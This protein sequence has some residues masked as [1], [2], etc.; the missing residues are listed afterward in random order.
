[1]RYA[2]GFDTVTGDAR[3]N[4][5]IVMGETGATLDGGAGDDFIH[6]G[7]GDD[8]FLFGRGSGADRVVDNA[9][10][11]PNGVDPAITDH[12]VVQF[13]ANID[14]DQLWFEQVGDD[15]RVSV[16][17]TADSI[18]VVDWYSSGVYL[19]GENRIDEFK[20]HSG[21]ALLKSQVDNLVSAM[22]AFS[23]PPMGQ[24]TLDQPRSDALG[25]LIAASWQ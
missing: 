16:I 7:A 5:I 22:A 6:A 24:L 10:S 21:E 20:T 18:T 9:V 14:A 1:M 11:W 2:N 15:L 25:S 17:G 23:P 13:G 4:E 3:D 19:P 8:T 12:D